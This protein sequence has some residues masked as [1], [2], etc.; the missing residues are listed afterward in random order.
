MEVLTPKFYKISEVATRWN[1]TINEILIMVEHRKLTAFYRYNGFYFKRKIYEIE[2]ITSDDLSEKDANLIN[3]ANDL[4]GAKTTKINKIHPGDKEVNP[5]KCFDNVDG[6]VDAWFTISSSEAS[7]LRLFGEAKL[8]TLVCN[9]SFEIFPGFEIVDR[10]P[11]KGMALYVATETEVNGQTAWR[12]GIHKITVEDLV[13]YSFAIDQAEEEFIYF[14]KSNCKTTNSKTSTEDP[15][16]QA[17]MVNKTASYAKSL[18]MEKPDGWKPPNGWISFLAKW[19][20]EN[21]PESL[22]LSPT[23]CKNIAT[24][25]NPDKSKGPGTTVS[26]N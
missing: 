23:A 19:V 25:A 16:D 12:R 4:F 8:S 15:K 5:A 11:D 14:D 6:M 20:K 10:R 13:F 2:Q 21:A 1:K 17:E 24:I 18:Q 9:F 3:C 7:I 26:A 22:K